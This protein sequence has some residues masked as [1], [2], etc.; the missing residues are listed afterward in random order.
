MKKII[1]SVA[2]L[3]ISLIFSAPTKPEG[4][5]TKKVRHLT[6][7]EH[8]DL[9]NK[10]IK[11]DYE[12]IEKVKTYNKKNKIEI[13]VEPKDQDDY[14]FITKTDSECKTDKISLAHKCFPIFDKIFYKYFITSKYFLT[15]G[16]AYKRC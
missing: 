3:N 6:N 4:Q 9:F 10:Q 13:K 1:F 2:L 8:T 5:M 7:E 15:P 16:N 11:C 14:D 12:L